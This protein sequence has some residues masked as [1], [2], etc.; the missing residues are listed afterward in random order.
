[1]KGIY[2][3]TDDFKLS[4]YTSPLHD[5]MVVRD[6]NFTPEDEK[7]PDVAICRVFSSREDA[8]NIAAF[9]QSTEKSL[10]ATIL[11][12]KGGQ[13]TSETKKA[14]VRANGKKGGRPRK[15]PEGDI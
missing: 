3:L 9:L 2:K 6:I 11:G 12:R 7:L 15:K 8:K 5:G 4:H 13:S 10:S 14:A 1:M